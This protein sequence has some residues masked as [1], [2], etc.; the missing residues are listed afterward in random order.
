MDRPYYFRYWQQIDPAPWF[1]SLEF[2]TWNFFEIWCL[3]LGISVLR[4]HDLAKK[5][6]LVSP[7]PLYGT[8]FLLKERLVLYGTD[9]E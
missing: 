1:G 8:D 5:A 4:A 3:V 7:K 9:E 6:D 2:G